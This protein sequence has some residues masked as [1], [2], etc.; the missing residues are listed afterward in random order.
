MS[1]FKKENI[2]YARIDHT[3]N[4]FEHRFEVE[5]RAIEFK[6]LLI[7]ECIETVGIRWE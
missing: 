5:R 7:L 2:R 1:V 6:G 3:D 4:E